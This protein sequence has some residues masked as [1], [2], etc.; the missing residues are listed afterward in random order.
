MGDRRR[1]RSDL[2]AATVERLPQYLRC[3]EQ[4]PKSQLTISSQELA[5]LSNLTAAGV[6][7]DLSYLGTFGIR[8]L[9]YRVDDLVDRIRQVLGLTEARRVVVVGIGNLGSALANYT[10]FG[11][12]GF[13]IVGL[14]DVDA[15][16]VD[17]TVG[18]IKVRHLSR[19][20]D[21]ARALTISVGIIATPFG[22]AQTVADLLVESGVSSI[23][24]FAPTV[25]QVPKGINLRYV[26]LATELRILGYY[27]T[28][29]RT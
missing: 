24:N 13:R 27:I 22:A 5:R 20:P 21:D 3:V 18:G 7:R 16:K 2:P 17:S 11:K 19:L 12:G 9:G 26:D 6:R 8:G 25:L 28:P 4:L 29:P 10:G 15:D 23:L 1:P 14:Y